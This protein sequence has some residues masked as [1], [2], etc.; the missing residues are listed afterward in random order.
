[1]LNISTDKIPNWPLTIF[2][3]LKWHCIRDLQILLMCT[4]WVLSENPFL[5]SFIKSWNPKLNHTHQSFQLLLWTEKKRNPAQPHAR[6]LCNNKYKLNKS[7]AL[8]FTK[9]YFGVGIMYYQ[10]TVSKERN[11][12]LFEEK[13]LSH[14]PII[15]KLFCDYYLNI[16]QHKT[17]CDS[18][19]LVPTN[20]K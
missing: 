2:L 17:K 14:S 10:I 19:Y 7:W 6:N 5:Y 20:L 11:V 3:S 9:A 15:N 18:L 16:Y 4:H 13:I 12:K 8:N 1:M